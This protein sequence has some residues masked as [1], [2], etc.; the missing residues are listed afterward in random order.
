MPLH[1]LMAA[2]L[3]V[4]FVLL[5]GFFAGRRHEFDADQTIGFS[6]LALRF[7]LPAALFVGMYSVN[8]ETLAGQGPLALVMVLGYA[9]LFILLFV[10]LRWL[11][12]TRVSATIFALCMSSSAVP[13]YGLALFRP[14]YSTAAGALV[15]MIALTTNLA[16]IS[17]AIFL[18]ET[19]R[20]CGGGD[21]MM[22]SILK[23]IQNPLVLAPVVGAI[24]V[25]LGIHLPDLLIE[26]LQLL[27][28][29][30][31]GVAIFASGLTLAAHRFAVKPAVF[32]GTL[33]KIIVQPAIF[34]AL[35]ILFRI[36]NTAIGQET[37]VA[38][39]M[40]LATP[41]VLFAAQYKE[42]EAE[43]SALM[44]LTTLAMIVTL[45]GGLFF[46]SHL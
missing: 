45:P 38:S 32:A 11:N 20:P 27:G 1:N 24:L 6:K 3:P 14:L 19:S 26:S 17:V 5:L 37:F 42:F 41:C 15:G 40:P 10:L 2:L 13:I 31:S 44:L 29:A 39:A 9:G 21:P 34:A 18:L 43:A 4:L 33:V 36:N 22:G 46:S 30:A 35:L 16:Q 23:T 7:S 25:M 28:S 12:Y 8:R